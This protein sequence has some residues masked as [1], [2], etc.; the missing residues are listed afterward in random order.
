VLAAAAFAATVSVGTAHA[1]SQ[2][3]VY[4]CSTPAGHHVPLDG[5]HREWSAAT[6]YISADERCGSGGNAVVALGSLGRRAGNVVR[7]SVTAPAGTGIA[8]AEIKRRVSI[9]PGA[10]D[11][12]AVPEWVIY[13]DAPTYDDD[14]ILERCSPYS[15]CSSLDWPSGS[16][17]AFRFARRTMA[18][19]WSV[20]CRGTGTCGGT[21]AGADGLTRA[22]GEVQ[23]MHL[24]MEDGVTPEA[25][26]GGPATESTGLHHDVE[27]AVIAATD[28]GS[29]VYQAAAF[30]DGKP[31]GSVLAGGDSCRDKGNVPGELDFESLAPCPA[32]ADGWTLPVDYRGIASGAHQLTIIV[33]DAAG[34][35]R[36]FTYP[37][38]VAGAAAATPAPAADS[39][40]P[41]GR[42]AARGHVTIAVDTPRIQPGE[43]LRVHGSAS[44]DELVRSATAVDV[45]V[46]VRSGWRTVDTVRTSD[47]GQWTWKRRLG[48]TARRGTYTFRAVLHTV[49]GG[50]PEAPASVSVAVKVS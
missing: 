15:Q 9:N 40:R 38:T 27:P 11:D 33:R 18:I 10:P 31:A 8:Y 19:H 29:G 22:V 36:P 21:S 43:T 5:F 6:D 49:G 1:K 16:T 13:R 4:M 25:T 12:N 17:P 37:V 24:L 30:I 35:E 23:G 44:T 26:V 50:A 20:E 42:S 41:Q 46:R 32:A 34:N 47:A 3:H 14:H 45:Q 7:E 2:Y 28:G 39:S 48:R